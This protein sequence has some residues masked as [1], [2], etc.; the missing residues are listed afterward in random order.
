MSN[1][2]VVKDKV[3]R[4]TREIFNDVR[5][6]DD[7]DLLIPIENTAIFVRVWERDF[8]STEQEKFFDE[9]Q[10]SKVMVNIWAYVLVEL[11]GSPELFK[12][13]AVDGQD[14]IVGH[15]LLVPTDDQESS[16]RLIF[17]DQ[18]PGDTLDPGELKEALLAVTQDTM[19]AALQKH[20]ALFS[21]N[22]V[23]L[24]PLP[25][26]QYGAWNE[27]Q[28]KVAQHEAALL[29]AR[30]RLDQFVPPSYSDIV[31]LPA[32]ISLS[33]PPLPEVKTFTMPNG[34]MVY[35]VQEKSVPRRA[36]SLVFKDAEVIRLNMAIA[37]KEA[38]ARLAGSLLLCGSQKRTAKEIDDLLSEK[39]CLMLVDA[40]RFEVSSLVHNFD[41][42]L[43]LAVSIFNERD[44]VQSYFDQKKNEFRDSIVA[45][46]NS[47]GYLLGKF[48]QKTL[49]KNY[50]WIRQEEQMLAEMDAVTFNDVRDC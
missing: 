43:A 27:L 48:L 14:C 39:G 21:M 41:E 2:L 29:Q 26:E 18:I 24:L 9:N 46:Q 5:I 20:A 45:S 35:V 50:P 16:F 44:F 36:C 28:A 19:R 13:V 40:T 6:D 7:G 42:S 10:L 33:L 1:I 47:P 4:F 32:R 11:Q 12:W 34:L 49:Y 31:N 15:F 22:K 38:A 8:E 3:Q 30:S 17:A 37:G 23:S 25:V